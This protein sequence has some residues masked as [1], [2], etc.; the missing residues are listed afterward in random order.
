VKPSSHVIFPAQ[1]TYKILYGGDDLSVGRHLYFLPNNSNVVKESARSFTTDRVTQQPWFREDS[2][3]LIHNTLPSTSLGE[4]Y[5]AGLEWHQIRANAKLFQSLNECIEE[6]KNSVPKT[7]T[8]VY[9]YTDDRRATVYAY[10]TWHFE[11][12]AIPM[13][14]NTPKDSVFRV[15]LPEDTKTSRLICVIDTIYVRSLLREETPQHKFEIRL[16]AAAVTELSNNSFISFE[17]FDLSSSIDPEIAKSCG[18]T[19]QSSLSNPST[20]S[21]DRTMF[22]NSVMENI[23]NT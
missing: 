3:L 8:R 21:M 11:T 18:F 1:A 10:L 19:A 6:S 12:E 16:L 15:V 22:R 4:V 14:K 9:L 5:F 13:R 2:V 20:W 7:K 17:R 23:V